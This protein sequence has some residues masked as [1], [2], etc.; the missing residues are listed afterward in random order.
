MYSRK[1]R[2]GCTYLAATVVAWLGTVAGAQAVV[3]D[4]YIDMPSWNA[5]VGTVKTQ[6]FDFGQPPR[7]YLPPGQHDLGLFDIRLNGPCQGTLAGPPYRF[8]ATAE[9]SSGCT[10]DLLFPSPIMG[11]G[12]DWRQTVTDIGH[13]TVTIAGETIEFDEYPPFSTSSNGDGFLGFV[14]DTPFQEARISAVG[15]FGQYHMLAFF[16]P[17]PT[18]AILVACGLAMLGVRRRRLH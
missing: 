5:A 3:V 8:E 4:V 12:A 1:I 7:I 16:V 6:G 2:L 13:L 15:G 11:F 14:S 9:P 18:T 17:E 10:Q